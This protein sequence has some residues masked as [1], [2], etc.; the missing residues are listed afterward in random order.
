MQ[1]HGSSTEPRVPLKAEVAERWVIVGT[2]AEWPV[3]LELAILDR[4]VVD[5]GD[6]PPHQ[7]V[8]VELPVLVA[9]AAKP[10]AGIVVPFICKAHG[11][12][13]VAERPHFLD[14]PIIKLAI[15]FARKKRLDLRPAVNE[16]GAIAPDA[17][18]G[19]GQRDTR[20]IARVPGIFG[21]A[22]L[23][24]GGLG[25]ERGQWWAGHGPTPTG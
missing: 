8:L 2:A 25:C 7:A 19:I 15:P 21:E 17:V 23:L 20:R 24:R 16:L 14:Q 11:D 18:D 22:R 9:I 12:P 6:A 4:Q 5:A 10:V 1:G 3:I 13:V